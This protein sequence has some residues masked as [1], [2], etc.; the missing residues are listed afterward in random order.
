M[1]EYYFTVRIAVILNLTHFSGGP[2]IGSMRSADS[3][4]AE[5][6]RRRGAGSRIHLFLRWLDSLS[7][8]RESLRGSSA[9]YVRSEYSKTRIEED[10]ILRHPSWRQER[11][12]L[13]GIDRLINDLS[14]REPIYVKFSRV[15][16]EFPGLFAE[17]S[18]LGAAKF[19][20]AD[21]EDISMDVLDEL[22]HLKQSAL[23]ESCKP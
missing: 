18:K 12:F 6:P 1:E 4:L 22:L 5:A 20:E 9:T 2:S 13:N 17:R 15:L 23:R 8:V 14:D 21:P 3:F 16:F 10:T 19:H 11:V 7:R